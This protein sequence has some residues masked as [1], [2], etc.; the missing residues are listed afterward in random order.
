[1]TRTPAPLVSASDAAHS[2]AF[3]DDA[4]PSKPTTNRWW[5]TGLDALVEVMIPPSRR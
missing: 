1:M 3:S 2:I 4:E 5:R